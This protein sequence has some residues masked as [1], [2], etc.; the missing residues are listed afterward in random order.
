MFPIRRTLA[1][2]HARGGQTWTSLKTGSPAPGPVTSAGE[3]E[4]FAYCPRNW[5]LARHG[6][7][8]NLDGAR[9][10][11]EGHRAAG[12]A[13]LSAQR[14]ERD[15]RTG[16]A[17]SLRV[18][19]VGLSGMLVVL[20]VFLLQGSLL[21]LLA[22]GVA[23]LLLLASS[24][25]LTV[26]LAS[27][28]RARRI[29]RD[30][31]LV[32]GRVLHQD[33]GAETPLLE[34]RAWGLSGRPDYILQTRS[35]T[36]PVEVKTGRTPAAAPHRSHALQLACYLRLVEATSGQ[37]P[38][39]GLLSYPEGTFR[40][41]WDAALQEDLRNTLERMA[42]ARATG[43]ADRDHEQPGRCRGCARRDACDQRLA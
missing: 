13:L 38:E 26:A 8:G 21:S 19:L 10:G 32:P 3:V 24:A 36:V 17:W 30:A 11:V 9:R 16:I 43:I 40:V 27:Q 22:L 18:S 35:G 31:H 20:G 7:E 25:L 29:Q 37:P 23:L 14:E 39:Y 41:A 34:D 1:R 15:F 33:I 28:V 12:A 6:V 5:Q 4:Q 42:V 2:L